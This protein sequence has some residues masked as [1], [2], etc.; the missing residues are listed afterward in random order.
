MCTPLIFIRITVL[1]VQMYICTIYSAD[2]VYLF[3]Q[4]AYLYIKF[5]ILA[6]LEHIRSTNVKSMYNGS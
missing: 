4:F 5:L 6:L 1:C 2:I 3:P